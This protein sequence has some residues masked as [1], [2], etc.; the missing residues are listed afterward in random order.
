MARPPIPQA[1][2]EL[3]RELRVKRRTRS[4]ERFTPWDQIAD[5]VARQG[6]GRFGAQDLAA[7]AENL[8]LESHPLARLN[9][10]MQQALEDGWREGWQEEFPGE[11]WPGM[12]AARARIKQ[13]ASG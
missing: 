8:P 4:G 1:A 3:A 11:P 2:A 12:E 13:R 5:E 7:A 9:E 10:R 6:H